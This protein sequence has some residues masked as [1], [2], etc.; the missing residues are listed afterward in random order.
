MQLNSRTAVFETTNTTAASRGTNAHIDHPGFN[1]IK[2]KNYRSTTNINLTMVFYF[3][4][5]AEK[6]HQ[7]T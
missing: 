4:R 7:K 5:A 6:I 3:L 2:K 1:R